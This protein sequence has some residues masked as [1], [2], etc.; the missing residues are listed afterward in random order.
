MHLA[1][2]I[3]TVVATRKYETLDGV[4]LLIIEPINE[5]QKPKS[6]PVIAVDPNMQAGPG[7]IVSYIVGREASL[8]LPVP[9]APVDAGIVGI[10]DD[11]N[12]ELK[13]ANKEPAI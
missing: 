5:E 13:K 4:K 3:G 6:D 2:V 1:K 10:V 7:S 12:V 11:I 9:F 8:G